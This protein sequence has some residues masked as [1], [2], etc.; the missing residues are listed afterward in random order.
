MTTLITAAE[1]T[2][3]VPNV[4]VNTVHAICATLEDTAGDG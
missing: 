4:D 3:R 1:E 2:K